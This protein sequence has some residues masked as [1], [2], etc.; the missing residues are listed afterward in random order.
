MFYNEPLPLVSMLI[1]GGTAHGML[2]TLSG[3]TIVTKLPDMP[4]VSRRTFGRSAAAA[5]FGT[6]LASGP[7]R[8]R[9]AESE[10]IIPPEDYRIQFGRLK[11]SVMSWCFQPIPPEELIEACH[12]LGMHAME[13]I[14][15]K[16]YPLI[17]EK[18]MAIALVSG[19][20]GFKKGPLDPDNRD[21]CIESLRKAIDLAAEVGSPNVITFTGMRK[22]GVSDEQADKN[23]IDVWKE[24]VPLAEEKG[25]NLC[26]EHLNSR[27]DSHPMK[28][29]PGYYGDDVDHCIDLIKHVDSLRMK[30]LFD[31]Y[32]VQ[33]M[34]GDVIRRIREYV[35]Y[36]GHVHT[37]GVPG[38][39]EMDDTQEINY[40]AV[41]RALL[42]A[43]YKGY[44]AQEFIPTWEDKLGALRHG[45]RVMDV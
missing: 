39:C 8:C 34:N 26:L 21:F 31:I 36:I 25:V 5:C 28:G 11:Q 41:L 27:D 24:V 44:V 15:E 4:V 16:Y 18:G 14:D 22:S 3:E 30:L 42:E 9:A 33:I 10:S 2:S 13:G 32:H 12:R 20:H 23:C 7:A 40:P 19:G 1:P 29:H 37:A 17:R 45:A 38:R 43:G 6:A 35:D